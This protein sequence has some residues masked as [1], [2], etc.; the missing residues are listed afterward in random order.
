M[1]AKAAAALV[2]AAL[3]IPGCRSDRERPAPARDAE[4]SGGEK[5]EGTD[6][7]GSPALPRKIVKLYFPSA[8][9][10]TLVTE[11]REIFDT[12]GAVDRA[13]QVLSELLA[14]PAG[15]SALPAVPPGTALRQVYLGTDGTGYA[16]FSAELQGGMDGGSSEEILTVYSI[17]DSV[18]LNVPEMKRLAILVD[19]RARATLSG[20]IDLR[21]P[22]VPDRTLM[23][24]EPTEEKKKDP[25]DG[26]VVRAPAAVELGIKEA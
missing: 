25:K 9:S 6:A 17:V 1:R 12:G 19:G 2:A 10:D 14:G 11:D 3:L 23:K 8:G 22:L 26:S 20:H 5:Q 13:K 15:E 16:D 4:A 7:A 21:R 24:G 18:L